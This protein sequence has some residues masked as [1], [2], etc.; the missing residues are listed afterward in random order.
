MVAPFSLTLIEGPCVEFPYG[1]FGL[2]TDH[3]GNGSFSG[4]DVDGCACQNYR[5]IWVCVM[6]AA[7]ATTTMRTCSLLLVVALLPRCCAALREARFRP[8]A[9]NATEWSGPEVRVVRQENGAVAW[10]IDGHQNVQPQFFKVALTHDPHA[11]DNWTDVDYELQ[12]ACK[13]AVPAVSFLINEANVSKYGNT[14]AGSSWSLFSRSFDASTEAMF[15]RV[16]RI[17]P[18][19]YLWPN[20]DA[21]LPPTSCGTPLDNVT[22][23]VSTTGSDYVD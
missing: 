23:R 16:E 8:G 5:Y 17:C 21:W 2:S 1:A 7:P 20:I 4:A 15:A 19:A 3:R 22:L 6:L 11:K 12:L 14:E 13:A 18:D 10:Q 9:N